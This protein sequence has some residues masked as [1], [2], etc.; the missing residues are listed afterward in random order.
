MRVK[1]KPVLALGAIALCLWHGAGCRSDDLSSYDYAV[2]IRRD[3]KVLLTTRPSSFEV[4]T[5]DAADR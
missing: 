5:A 1:W 2:E 4:I 3:A